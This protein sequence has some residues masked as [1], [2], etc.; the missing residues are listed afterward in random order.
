MPIPDAS[1]SKLV[2]ILP[3]SEKL[4]HKSNGMAGVDTFAVQATTV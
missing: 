1:I 4:S 2:H 3:S